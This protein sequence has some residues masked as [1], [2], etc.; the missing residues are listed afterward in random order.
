MSIEE[1]HFQNKEKEMDICYSLRTFERFLLWFGLIEI[2]Q[3]NDSVI[4][5]SYM[6]RK[7]DIFDQ[8]IIFE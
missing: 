7:S 2:T 6:V 8:L 5:K 4:D 3:N 1:T